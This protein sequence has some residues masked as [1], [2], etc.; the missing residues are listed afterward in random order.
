[1]Q[2]KMCA[3][4]RVEKELTFF[5]PTKQ[6][7]KF[8]VKSMCKDCVTEYRRDW[9]TKNPQRHR[10]HCNKAKETNR[11]KI[12]TWNRAYMERKRKENPEQIALYQQRSHFKRNY[13]VT[14]KWRDKQIETQGNLCA[15]CK[16]APQQQGL[17]VD[18]CHKTGK[19]REM[20]CNH[21]NTGLHRMEQDIEWFRAA[22]AYLRRHA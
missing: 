10:D 15:I 20:L 8:G 3:K 14:L 6:P 21:C 16:Q 4:C 22:E 13:G 2:I 17:A 1:M 12:R 9:I 19:V 7:L 18:H 11:E 5:S